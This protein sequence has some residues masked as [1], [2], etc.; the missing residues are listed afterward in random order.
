MKKILN[1][2]QKKVEIKIV[3]ILIICIL[4]IIIYINTNYYVKSDYYEF[5]KLE[6]KSVV[7]QK[8]DQHPTRNNPI[9]LKNGVE[10]RIDRTIFDKICVGDSVIKLKNSDSVYY[11][12]KSKIYIE[13][14]N[15]FK[16][17]KYLKSLK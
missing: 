16:R 9:Y 8:N 14:Y 12:T 13:D 2:I 4:P 7:L 15:A 1:L 11:H 3:G 5:N 17:E 6:I 10:L